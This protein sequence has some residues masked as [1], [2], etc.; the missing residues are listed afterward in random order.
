MSTKILGNS[1][2]I[3]HF[4]LENPK[5]KIVKKI[6][7]GEKSERLIRQA[8]KQKNFKQSILKSPEIISVLQ[9]E[10][11]VII[12]MPFIDGSDMVS[13]TCY[14]DFQDFINVT[15]KL[16]SFL[17]LEFQ[18]STLDIFPKSIWE[19]KVSL[20]LTSESIKSKITSDTLLAC[21]LILRSD[22]PEF[23][24]MGVCH[25]DLTLSNMLVL[26]DNIYL[27][28]FLNPPIETPYEDIS[29]LLIDCQYFW[30]LQKY[31]EDC[32]KTKVMIMW[33]Y[34]AEKIKNKLFELVDPAI[35]KKFQLLGLLRM[36]PYTSNDDEIRLIIK[37]MK[38]IIKCY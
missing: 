33:E 20:L 16:I 9:Q 30:S 35:V 11:T 24:P 4:L 29:K 21:E 13:Y 8:E 19:S 3:L 7:H 18:E 34:L 1:G 32:D 17:L 6:C 5:S 2:A 37:S 23:I 28:D 25:G 31:A 36:L 38:D 27:I 15:E 14:S 22:L 12:E 10:E 26:G